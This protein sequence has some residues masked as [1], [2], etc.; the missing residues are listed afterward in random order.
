MHEALEAGSIPVLAADTLRGLPLGSD[1]AAACG[2]PPLPQVA[3]DWEGELAPLLAA[4]LL[5][6]GGHERGEGESKGGGGGDGAGEGAGQQDAA[7]RR[8]DALQV[9]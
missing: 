7:G 2:E 3:V 8:L 1:A 5:P 9:Q 6:G 4:A